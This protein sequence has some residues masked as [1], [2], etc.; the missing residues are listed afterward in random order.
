MINKHDWYEIR[1][2]LV[3]MNEVAK[4]EDYASITSLRVATNRASIR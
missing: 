3:A 4:K 1:R 2:L